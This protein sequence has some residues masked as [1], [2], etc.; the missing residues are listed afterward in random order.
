MK[1][2]FIRFGFLTLFLAALA[3]SLASC[4]DLVGAAG[5]NAAPLPEGKAVLSIR[6]G[7]SS[8]ARTALPEA[9]SVEFSSF[10]LEG[11]PSESGYQTVSWQSSDGIADAE[12]ELTTAE[13]VVTKGLTYTFTLTATTSG[14]AQYKDSKNITI[15]DGENTLSFSLTLVS[16]G[17]GG[18][19]SAVIGVTLPETESGKEIT[20]LT[21]T[22]YTVSDDGT[23][24][25]TPYSSELNEKEIPITNK[26]ASFDSGD[27][28]PGAYCAV[29]RLYGGEDGSALAGTWREFFGIL[30]GLTSKSEINPTG[31]EKAVD[32]LYAIT[33]H[34]NDTEEE[35]ATITAPKC[36]SR[37]S[38]VTLEAVMA[39]S[40]R[41]GNK[42]EGW[43][44]DQACTVS[45]T[46]TAGMTGDI[47]LWAKWN[48]AYKV[49]FGE[50]SSE[51][52]TPAADNSMQLAGESV[53]ISVD[54]D[55]GYGLGVITVTAIDA[56]GNNLAVQPSGFPMTIERATTPKTFT[57]PGGLPYHGGVRVD[58]AYLNVYRIT[59]E[60]IVNGEVTPSVTE[61]LEGETITL[62][63]KPT[64]NY[65]VTS[66][67]AVKD[68]DSGTVTLST[69]NA[70]NRYK[71]TFTMPA[72]DVTVSAEFDQTIQMTESVKSA[73]SEYY[74]FGDYPQSAKND[75]VSVWSDRTKTNG[76]FTYIQ[77]TDDYFYVNLGG[78]Y[79]KVE[80]IKWKRLTS[81]YGGKSLL[82]ASSI[83]LGRRWD[84]DSNNW[85]NSEI[86]S[87]LNEG[88]INTAFT[89]MA[90]EK[91]ATTTV[92]NSEAST[93]PASNSKEWNSGK[94][95][96]ACANTSDKIFLLSEKEATTSAYGFAEY[97]VAD[98]ARI[99][100]C[101]DYAK[102]TGAY[103]STTAGYGGW[104]WLRSPRYY[105]S[106]NARYI[107]YDGDARYIND[108]SILYGGVV[109]A[110][111]ISVGN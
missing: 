47:E 21:V 71:R 84:D 40:S 4:S 12:G 25:S 55:E 92:D 29:F 109:P 74:Y 94:K 105:D 85:A 111:S 73:G 28:P 86:R 96:Y 51:H 13:I 3:L 43:Y 49:T 53:T 27:L 41:P 60:A 10:T 11:V 65:K 36:Y 95:Q 88:F 37:N 22:V 14:G 101:T 77:G 20:R 68:A 44:T 76:E 15:Q 6:L 50:S 38:V 108:V 7:S 70:Y 26:K 64:L 100:Y 30:G 61:S 107:N 57:M 24:N 42:I 17:T 66:L 81:N 75:G 54:L 34:A 9:E 58:V 1:K 78:T 87:W 2:A 82:H 83:L 97:N 63:L 32:E 33:Y 31:S 80:P 90:R 103:Y 8:K 102:A 99:R 110:L 23:I 59:V 98:S 45:F 89:A 106:S 5:E 67:E 39:L 19:G 16:L 69:E 93:N 52:G 35:K 46:S 79:Y 48:E 62:T 104:G 72:S 91:I 18:T 56:E